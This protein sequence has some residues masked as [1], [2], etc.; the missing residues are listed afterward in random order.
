MR[1]ESHDELS[2]ALRQLKIAAPALDR[3]RL[4]FEA[5]RRSMKRSWVWLMATA[6]S[7]MVTCLSGWM[8]WQQSI[9]N[10]PQ[11]ARATS[12][13]PVVEESIASQKMTV[14]PVEAFSPLSYLALRE[15][16]LTQKHP[17]LQTINS[18]TKPMP[19][20]SAGSYLL[21]DWQR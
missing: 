14:E 3:D 9:S 1:T 12:L 17:V 11:E 20:L 15:G 18:D 4:L 16:S 8:V 7:V 21:P 6:A 19:I 5:G 13:A 2:Q 10:R